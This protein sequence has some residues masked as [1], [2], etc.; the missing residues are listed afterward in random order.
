MVQVCTSNSAAHMSEQVLG[1]ILVG[2][3]EATGGE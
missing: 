2:S 1:I 3:A